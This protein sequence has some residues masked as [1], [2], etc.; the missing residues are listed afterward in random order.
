MSSSLY[1][2]VE[3]ISKSN[4][5]DDYKKSLIE[6]SQ[7]L[8]SKNLP[9]IFDAYHLAYSI[10]IQPY[11]IINIIKDRDHIYNTYRVRKKNWRS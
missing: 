3:Q 2:I 5:G 1:K 11:R 4:H 10:G 6:Y 9:I 8:S 7:N